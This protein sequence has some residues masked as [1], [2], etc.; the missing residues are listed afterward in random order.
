MAREIAVLVELLARSVY[1]RWRAG[2]LEPNAKAQEPA[3]LQNDQLPDGPIVAYDLLGKKSTRERLGCASTPM[4]AT[5]RN[6]K[7]KPR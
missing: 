3:G 2:E 6:G 7:Q 5:A 1:K 4:P